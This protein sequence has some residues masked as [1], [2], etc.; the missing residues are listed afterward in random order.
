MRAYRD[1]KTGKWKVGTR[2]NPIYDNKE[3]AQRACMDEL[4]EALRRVKDKINESVKN[5]GK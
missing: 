4:T 2:G 5:Y 1:K 3:Q